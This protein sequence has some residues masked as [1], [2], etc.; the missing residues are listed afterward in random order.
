[1]S[2]K[3]ETRGKQFHM[4]L[5]D[6]EL[7]M[8]KACANELGYTALSEMTRDAVNEL[9]KRVSE[10]AVLAKVAV[11]EQLERI[12]TINTAFDDDRDY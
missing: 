2:D 8:W 12:A 10:D 7:R 6:T 9:Q 11:V 1:M 3:R 4:R 5:S